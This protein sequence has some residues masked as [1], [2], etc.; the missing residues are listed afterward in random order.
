MRNEK[1]KK[2]LFIVLEVY[3]VRCFLEAI[4]ENSEPYPGKS[5]SLRERA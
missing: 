4:C 3:K 5:T 2:F 1:D